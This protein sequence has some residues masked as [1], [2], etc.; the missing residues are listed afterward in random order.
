[1]LYEVITKPTQSGRFPADN[2]VLVEGFLRRCGVNVVAKGVLP[3]YLDM[4]A[5]ALSGDLPDLVITSGGT[6]RSERDFAHQAAEQAGFTLLFNG[7]DMRPGS[8]AAEAPRNPEGHQM[9]GGQMESRVSDQRE[10]YG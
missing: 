8:A 2:L 5:G 4:V 6:G 1:M 9:D 7:V 10:S 3:D